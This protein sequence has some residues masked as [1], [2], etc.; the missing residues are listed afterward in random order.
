MEDEVQQNPYDSLEEITLRAQAAANGRDEFEGYDSDEK[1]YA[2]STLHEELGALRDEV[3]DLGI[4]GEQLPEKIEEVMNAV[5][6]AYDIFTKDP[7][8][9]TTSEILYPFTPDNKEED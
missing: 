1:A 9:L 5:S 6:G 3:V 2:L 8:E 4:Y 7:S